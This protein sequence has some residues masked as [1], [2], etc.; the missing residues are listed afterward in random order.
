MS[1]R[2]PATQPRAA[3][4]VT[5]RMFRAAVAGSIGIVIGW[6][7]VGSAADS[8]RGEASWRTPDASETIERMRSALESL[9]TAPDQVDRSSELLLGGLDEGDGDRLSA[10]VI[11]VAESVPAIARLHELAEESPTVAAAW[12]T[13]ADPL[14]A[15]FDQLPLVL[16][17]SARSWLAR[18]LVYGR[19]YDEALPIFA[20]VDATDVVDPAA[21]LFYRGVCRHSLLYKKE[22]LADL[23]RL[24]E[25]EDDAPLR[26]VRT[27]QL[28][29]ADIK[30]L[31]DDSL[32]EVS[33]LM[34]D[35][36]RRLDLGRADS[37]VQQREQTII[38]KLSKLI[39][40][41][42]EQQRQQQQQQQQQAAGGSGQGGGS[43]ARPM[44]DSQIAG[45]SGQGDVDRKNI[46]QRSGWGNL[47]PAEREEALQQISRDLPTHYR[48]AIEAYFRKLASGD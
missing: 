42:E 10:F 2:H 21:V 24:L 23:R 29:I 15:S 46:G 6:V 38:D 39:E 34:T 48:E 44:E 27:A 20:D 9:G 11:A 32:D 41:M 19:L 13:S 33:R 17:A 12:F 18:E 37:D 1:N 30:P 3:L 8:L 40:D 7:T 22:A 25:N 26:F 35:V 47:P 31:K 16:V 5:R 28:M 4:V 43:G 14:A 36:T 45:G